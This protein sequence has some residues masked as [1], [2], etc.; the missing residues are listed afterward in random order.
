MENK[1]FA[2]TQMLLGV[3]RMQKLA[4][5]KVMIVGLGA[6]GG[7]ALEALARSGVGR[8]ILIDFDV[9]E[10]SN[11]NRQILA[12]SHTLGQKKIEAARERVLSINP[13]AE[14]E[15]WDIFVNAETIPELIAGQPDL[16]I[17]AID[18]LN[19]KCDLMQA[20]QSAG[21]PFI[22]SMGA[23]L[24][25]DASQ[26]RF[27][28]LSSSKNCALAKFIRK[29]LRHR[30][31][32]ISSIKCVWS[33]EQVDLPAGALELPE[34]APAEGRCRHTMGSLPTITAIFGLTIA[35]QAILKLSGCK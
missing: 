12:T 28:A 5:A 21:I 10:E 29:R 7:Y 32:D 20:L 19:P 26:I 15:V 4:A 22:S 34:T 16:V 8:F 23:A 3:E 13:T 11:I 27:G 31:V 18:A 6:V 24:K 2:R 35:N 30:G 33:D 17:D 25:T 9:F 14:V 1:R